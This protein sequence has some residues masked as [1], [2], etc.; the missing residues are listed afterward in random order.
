MNYK[1]FDHTLERL[2]L[3]LTGKSYPAEQ[4]ISMKTQFYREIRPLRDLR[5]IRDTGRVK[6]EEIVGRMAEFTEEAKIGD[7]FGKSWDTHWFL[8]EIEVPEEWVSA[9]ESE[10]HFLWNGKCEASLWTIDG[11][12]ILQAFTENVRETYIVKRPGIKDDLQD[13]SIN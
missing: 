4:E 1:N 11:K 12:R 2:N 13:H 5:V 8:V 7:L 10:V 6:A 3:F 9:E